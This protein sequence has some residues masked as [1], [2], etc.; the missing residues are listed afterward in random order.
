MEVVMATEKYVPPTPEE[1]ARAVQ[2]QMYLVIRH[3]TSA[4]YWADARGDQFGWTPHIEKA[5]R[6]EGKNALKK[7]RKNLLEVQHGGR[8]KGI[9]AVVTSVVP[10]PDDL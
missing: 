7:A 2:P 10:I 6:F 4:F 5:I 3:K 1:T 8:E 9:F